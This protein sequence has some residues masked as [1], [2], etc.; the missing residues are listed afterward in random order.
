MKRRRAFRQRQTTRHNRDETIVT[1]RP[2]QGI[3]LS[4]RAN[5]NANTVGNNHHRRLG[6]T[7]AGK[8]GVIKPVTEGILSTGVV[9]S[10]IPEDESSYSVLQGHTEKGT[11][12]FLLSFVRSRSSA[13]ARALDGISRK[14]N[15]SSPASGN[16]RSRSPRGSPLARSHTRTF[17]RSFAQRR[18]IRTARGFKGDVASRPHERARLL[19]GVWRYRYTAGGERAGK[20]RRQSRKGGRIRT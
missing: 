3:T 1:R 10:V 11:P 19:T 2:Q 13:R 18:R 17:V 15:A 7:R 5:T 9:Q 14:T 16:T 12:N 6:P 20:I 8:M 4:R